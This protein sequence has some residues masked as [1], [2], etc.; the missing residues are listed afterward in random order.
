MAGN[1]AILIT[2]WR[3][4]TSP[5]LPA[6]PSDPGNKTPVISAI[7]LTLYNHTFPTEQQWDDKVNTKLLLA[8]ALPQTV[9]SCGKAAGG[10]T[11]TALLETP[12]NNS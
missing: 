6:F 11:T 3:H 4:G 7:L 1:L 9:V 8:L 10:L 5:H 12:H 2:A